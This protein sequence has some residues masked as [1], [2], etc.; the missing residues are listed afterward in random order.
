MPAARASQAQVPAARATQAQVPAARASQAQVSRATRPLSPTAELKSALA[1]ERRVTAAL[2][3]VSLAVGSTL[4]PDDLFELVLSRATLA[5]EADRATLYVLDDS[6][7]E[8]VSRFVQGDE[9][10]SIRLKR[11]QGVAGHVAE[12][13]EPVLVPD[14][15]ADPR[16]NPEWDLTSGYRTRSIVAVPMKNHVGRT[17]GVLQVLNKQDGCFGDADVDVLGALATQ[18]AVAI[19]SAQLVAKLSQKNAEL[20]RLTESLEHKVRDLALLFELE[21]ATGHASSVDA[22]ASA[23]LRQVCAS[24]DVDGGAIAIREGH[25][26]IVQTHLYARAQ[27]ALRRLPLRASAGFAGLVMSSGEVLVVDDA[28]DDPRK[29]PEID[30][31]LGVPVRSAFAVPLEGEG[32]ETLGALVLYN[33]RS[34]TFTEDDRALILL[35]AA[36]LSTA[37]RLLLAREAREREERLGTIGKLLSG[38]LHDLKTPLTVISGYVQL[39]ETTDDR[40]LR[41]EFADLALKQF[42]HI[43]AMQRDV[44]EFARGEKSIL[45]RKVYL[46]KFFEDLVRELETV[47]AKQRVELVVELGDRGTAR[48]DEG[49][50]LRV[51]QNLAR[52]AAEAMLPQGGGTF[53]IRVSRDKAD[54]RDDLVVV[55]SDTGPGIPREIQHR[56]FQSFVTSGK[57]GGTG[58]GLAITQRIA[59]EHGGTM[60]LVPTKRG[61]TFELRLPQGAPG[62]PSIPPPSP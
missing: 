56:L 40:K 26:S 3:D 46:Q 48:F 52:N 51:V 19:E 16:F 2:R 37:V 18:A 60:R 15:Y 50:V 9:V 23:V 8:L 44:L 39:M 57:K 54:G 61:A 1:H 47:L 34:A 24:S 59:E 28:L 53:T 4:D 30:A 49:K 20:T 22:L 7:G 33:K 41:G 14:A 17:I 12:H 43:G 10:R 32:D 31:E 6:T 58:L 42:E 45:V 11:G 29:N 21:R 35:V 55:F 36:N 27:D 13:G 62:S 5:V 38:V 25:G